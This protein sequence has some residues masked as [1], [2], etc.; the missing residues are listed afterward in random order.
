MP[1]DEYDGL[2]S[3]D[4]YEYLDNTPEEEFLHDEMLEEQQEMEDFSFFDDEFEDDQN[5]Q[6][7]ADDIPWEE[8]EDDSHLY[9]FSSLF[10]EIDNE[11]DSEPSAPNTPAP[12][13]EESLYPDIFEEEDEDEE[14]Q[15]SL[16]LFERILSLIP[17]D[18]QCVSYLSSCTQEQR[19]RIAEATTNAVRAWFTDKRDKMFTIPGG[20]VTVAVV[21]P[22]QDPMTEMQRLQSVAAVMQANGKAA[23]TGLFLFPDSSGNIENAE[24][25]NVSPSAFTV[26][27]W[28]TVQLLADRISKK[29]V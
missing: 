7:P 24:L 16:P 5:E 3:P 14:E 25:K 13:A 6:T 26:W 29:K 15:K 19:D 18:S 23:W 9:A 12:E 2:I 27:Q 10:D 22:S 1:T 11:E 8:D 21:S 20:S 28:R 4:A 17:K